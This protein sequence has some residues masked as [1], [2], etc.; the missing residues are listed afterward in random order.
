MTVVPAPPFG[1]DAFRAFGAGDFIGHPAPAKA[2]RRTVGDKRGNLGRL[3][4]G[5]KEQWARFLL[6]LRPRDTR[7]GG[8][9]QQR[10]RALGKVSGDRLE[11]PHA[12][13][14]ETLP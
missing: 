10:L 7:F 14:A 5:Q 13:R 9:R 6:R 3:R 1:A 8:G 2:P 12:V 4:T 11:P